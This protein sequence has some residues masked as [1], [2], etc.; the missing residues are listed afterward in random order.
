MR[1]F[2][3]RCVAAACGLAVLISCVSA[4]AQM[5]QDSG[6][7][8]KARPTAKKPQKT[9]ADESPWR[10]VEFHNPAVMVDPR[11]GVRA[12]GEGVY[13]G[14]TNAVP[15]KTLIVT[16]DF[17]QDP[18]DR[19]EKDPNQDVHANLRLGI[20][21]G[22]VAT[23]LVSRF[24]LVSRDGKIDLPCKGYGAKL[25]LGAGERYLHFQKPKSTAA[26][27]LV[28]SAGYFAPFRMKTPA[29]KGSLEQANSTRPPRK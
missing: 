16:L 5:F 8:T 20:E 4:Q 29:R 11:T 12:R 23:S 27:Y 1:Q 15:G 19:I 26:L 2:P 22:K 9:P 17:A 18:G 25:G 14:D 28:D 21:E 6:K 10:I 13:V 24:R 3:I 7:R